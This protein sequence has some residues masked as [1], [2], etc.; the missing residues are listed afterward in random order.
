M[1]WS[2]AAG[3][4]SSSSS[5]SGSGSAGAGGGGGGGG[6]G[7]GAGGSGSGSDSHHSHLSASQA[8][9]A[10]RLV[11]GAVE[12]SADSVARVLLRLVLKAWTEWTRCAVLST[13]AYQQL[14]CDLAA[15]HLALPFFASSAAPPAGAG[16]GAGGAQQRQGG[17]GGAPFDPMAHALLLEE[18]LHEAALSAGERCVDPRPVEPAVCLAIASAFLGSLNLAAAQNESLKE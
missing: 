14:Q 11:L 5:G 8:A 6:G 12:F 18:M 15:V 9:Q 13:G 16:A 3:G 2:W 7:W 10:H 1:P 17:G 4:G